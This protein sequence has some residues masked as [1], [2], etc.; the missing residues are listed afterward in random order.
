MTTTTAER[1]RHFPQMPPRLDGESDSAYTDR[2]TG[3]DQ[4]RRVPYDHPRNRQCSIGYHGECSDPAGENCKCPCHTEAGKLEIRLHDLEE[5]AVALYAVATG[6]LPF[7]GRSPDWG[8]R[9]TAGESECIS[10][11]VGRR[12]QLGVWYLGT[13]ED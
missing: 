7:K 12:P 8:L 13:E 11:I 3:A 10:E 2:L 5:T 9:I 4:T 1:A 6:Q